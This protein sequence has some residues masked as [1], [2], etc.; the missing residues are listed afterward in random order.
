MTLLL[1]Q[2]SPRHEENV[3]VRR[4]L[5]GREAK[6]LVQNTR[7]VVVAKD[8]QR[9]G[10]GAGNRDGACNEQ[11]A[12]TSA[13]ALATLGWGNDDSAEM[14]RA[15]LEHPMLAE[16]DNDVIGI[17]QEVAVASGH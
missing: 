3:S 5:H 9:D 14:H 4:R 11:G 10:T 1:Q 13:D 7:S 2:P 15:R 6:T 8:A 16:S 17:G 12:Q